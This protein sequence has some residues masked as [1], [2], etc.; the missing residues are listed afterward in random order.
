MQ[1]I[2]GNYKEGC[3][4]AVENEYRA[5]ELDAEYVDLK[6]AGPVIMT[7]TVEKNQDT[8]TF[9]GQLKTQV[10][11]TCGRCLASVK[12]ELSK[13]FEFYYE[14]QGKEVVETLNDLREVLLLD[15]PLSY[16]C[17][18][19]CKG[20]CPHCGIN[21]NEDSCTCTETSKQ[22]S[23][24]ALKDYQRKLQKEKTNGTP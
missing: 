11:R 19:H 10:A 3:A 4:T 21:F 1:I 13:N 15:H 14:I 23:F 22:S 5:D 16:I 6:Y 17:S 7:G 18:E 24:A 9:R 2:L 12:Q 20:L 8:L